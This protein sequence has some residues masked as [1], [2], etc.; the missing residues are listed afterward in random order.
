MAEQLISR[1]LHGC[2]NVEILYSDGKYDYS[3]F[4]SI[5]EYFSLLKKSVEFNVKDFFSLDLFDN[6]IIY[7]FKIGKSVIYYYDFKE[8]DLYPTMHGKRFKLHHPNT[9]FKIVIS[10]EYVDSIQAYKYKVFQGRKTELFK[11]CL[12]NMLGENKL[13]LGT[14]DHH[15]NNDVKELLLRFLEGNYTHGELKVNDIPLNYCLNDL[16]I[17]E[18]KNK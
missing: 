5:E 16:L 14:I 7:Y 6:G 13:C 17:R 3:K 15:F 9:I 11:Y 8:C 18:E 12:P 4:I 10:G 2:K 1:I